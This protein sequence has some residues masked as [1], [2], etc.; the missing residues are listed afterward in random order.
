[1][2]ECIA[3]GSFACGGALYLLLMRGGKG[4]W[5]ECTI[6]TTEGH[7]HGSEL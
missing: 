3:C 4:G 7:A 6:N 1:M 2:E 5:V